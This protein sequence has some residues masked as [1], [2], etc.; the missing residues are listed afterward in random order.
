VSI[1]EY[2]INSLG[3]K[4][5]ET[6]KVTPLTRGR[7]PS[8]LSKLFNDQST[9]DVTSIL[10]KQN[11][12]KGKLYGH[13]NIISTAS[14]VLQMNFCNNWMDHKQIQIKQV[15]FEAFQV[16]LRFIYMDDISFDPGLFLEVLKIAHRFN[17]EQLL[18]A[19]TSNESFEN[20]TP[21]HIWDFLS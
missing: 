15:S 18:D 1:K 12:E 8:R 20:N 10:E 13:V 5:S 17:V 19:L 16:L 4:M 11:G 2:V 6:I 14:H 3:L 9:S 21:L 7:L